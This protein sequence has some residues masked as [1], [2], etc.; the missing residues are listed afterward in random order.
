MKC[1]MEKMPFWPADSSLLA[2]SSHSIKWAGTFPTQKRERQIWGERL[3]KMYSCTVALA[4]EWSLLRTRLSNCQ[5]R[6]SLGD[7]CPKLLPLGW[8]FLGQNLISA[9]ARQ[10]SS[11]WRKSANTWATPDNAE[12]HLP[13]NWKE[14]VANRKVWKVEPS[15]NRMARGR[16]KEGCYRR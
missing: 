7:N 10:I 1:E 5:R 4:N 15:F 12:K 3:Q 6:D 14:I 11:G 9:A 16:N 2:P 13:G 8:K